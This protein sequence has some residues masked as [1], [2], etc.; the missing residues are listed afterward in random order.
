MNNRLAELS[1][2]STSDTSQDLEAGTSSLKVPLLP[3]SK[4]RQLS[5]R[6]AGDSGSD[7]EDSLKGFFREVELVKVSAAS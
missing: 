3:A 4:D 5:D 7:D 6:A 2:P 1:G